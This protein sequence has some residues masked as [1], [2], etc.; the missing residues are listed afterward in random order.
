[1]AKSGLIAGIDI[2]GTKTHLLVSE[3]GNVVADT[4]VPTSDRR[5]W[6]RAADAAALTALITETAY[7]KDAGISF[8]L[9]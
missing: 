4:V 8:K 7:W 2:G 9:G 3:D 6:D 5:T 1:M